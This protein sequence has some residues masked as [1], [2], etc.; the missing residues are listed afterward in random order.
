[1]VG[2]ALCRLNKSRLASSPVSMALSSPVAPLSQ[3]SSS[4]LLSQKLEQG[5]PGNSNRGWSFEKFHRE[6]DVNITEEDV[7]EVS[8][9]FLCN[10]GDQE[11][12]LA[13]QDPHMR[14][15]GYQKVLLDH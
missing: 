10:L 11:A 14:F 1:M 13:N 15:F 3:G 8:A 2:Q 12:L 4:Q 6:A 7:H 9:Y 5:G